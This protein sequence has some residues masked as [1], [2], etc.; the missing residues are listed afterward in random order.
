MHIL[1]YIKARL[2][3]KITYSGKEFNDLRPTGWVDADYGGGILTRDAHVQ[4]M[5]S[6]RQVNR[7]LGVLNTNQQ[8]HSQ[9]RRLN[10]WQ[11][12]MQLNKYCGCFQKWKRLGILKRT[13]GPLQRQRRC[14][15]IDQEY[16]TQ[17]THQTHR[18]PRGTWDVVP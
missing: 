17:L 5:F 10:T 3:Y 15:R 18:H 4:V 1:Q 6:F 8:L 2:H 12:H 14:R 7:Q 11:F 9:L 13:G 16:Q